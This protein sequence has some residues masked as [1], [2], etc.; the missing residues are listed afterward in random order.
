MLHCTTEYPAPFDEINL[1]AMSVM[2]Q[3]FNLPIGYSDHTVGIAIPLAA[4]ALGAVIIEKHFTLD[5]TLPGPDHKAS[6]DPNELIRMVEG[7]RQVEKA[8]GTGL[9]APTRSESKNAAIA[10]KSLVAAENIEQGSLFTK[11][12]L[13]VKRPGTGLKPIKYWSILGKTATRSYSK[14]EVIE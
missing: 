13:C 8:I 12:N 9:K 11:D 4:T 2:S 14:D 1:K 10:R 5:K 3:S 6:I 7:I